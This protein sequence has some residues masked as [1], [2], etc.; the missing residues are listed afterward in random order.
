[1]NGDLVPVEQQKAILRHVGPGLWANYQNP[2]KVSAVFR[3]QTSASTDPLLSKLKNRIKCPESM[4]E[5]DDM[6]QA[7]PDA[8]L[9]FEDLDASEQ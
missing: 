1:M 4:G 8:D 3:Q 6:A 9:K 5:S 2:Q 7:A